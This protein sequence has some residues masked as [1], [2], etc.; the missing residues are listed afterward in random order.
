MRFWENQKVLTSFYSQCIK[1]VCDRYHVT[2][3]ELNILMF[4][5]NNPE[6]DT[7]SE[8]IR[9]R[10]LTKSHVSSAL[11]KLE[12]RGFIQT[13]FRGKNRKTQHI[14]IQESAYPLIEAGKHAQREFARKLFL[15]FTEEEI[16]LFSELFQKTCRNAR[17]GMEVTEWNF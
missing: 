12:S 6:Y 3:M 11:K 17:K 1:P 16:K 10:M 4:L 9:I 5:T 8:I 13:Y 15:D 14:S 2:Q 7:A